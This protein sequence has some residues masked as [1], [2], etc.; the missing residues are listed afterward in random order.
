[1]KAILV[2]ITIE[3]FFP[4]VCERRRYGGSTH[5]LGRHDSYYNPGRAHTVLIRASREIVRINFSISGAGSC[6]LGGA[7][8]PVVL[9]FIKEGRR[10]SGYLKVTV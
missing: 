7:P 6:R 10:D 8:G 5:S 9:M 3:H 1:M 2:K 4:L